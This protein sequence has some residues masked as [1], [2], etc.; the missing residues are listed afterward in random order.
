MG[1]VA[2]D[3]LRADGTVPL[4]EPIALDARA[5]NLT[6]C[7]MAALLHSV[8]SYLHSQ[9]TLSGGGVGLGRPGWGGQVEE[10]GY[11]RFRRAAE[12]P[13]NLVLDVRR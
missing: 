7:P 9:L 5:T 12:T 1:H 13:L 10:A 3:H 6:G 4:V 11:T 2:C 8:V